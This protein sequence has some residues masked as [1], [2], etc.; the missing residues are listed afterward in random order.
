MRARAIGKAI[1]DRAR[2]TDADLIVLGSSPRW[3]RQSRFFSPTV[4][5]VLRQAPCEVI[6]VAFP[7]R[8][9][10]EELAL[11]L[12]GHEPTR[13]RWRVVK[14]LVVGCGRVGSAVALQLRAA[15]WDVSVIDEHEDALGRLGDDWTGEF[16]VGHGMDIQL[17]RTAGIED[18]D[19]VVVTTDGDNSNIVIGQMAQ[20]KFGVPLRHRPDPRPGPRRL[21]QDPRPRRRLPDPER[22]RDAHDRRPRRRGRSCA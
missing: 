9:L 20:K 15:G 11:G 8:V 14:V 4:D 3:R 22:D 7:Q 19:A 5:F 21:L 1:V 17:L 16:H 6:I 18:A 2:E 13:L 10:D 12:T